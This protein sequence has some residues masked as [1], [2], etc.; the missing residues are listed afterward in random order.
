MSEYQP[1]YA[2]RHKASFNFTLFMA[3]AVATLGLF[4]NPA[5]VVLGLGFAAYS[6][7]TTPSNYMLFRD[8]LMIAYGRPRYK[9]I[10][11]G[12]IDGDIELVQLAIASPRLKVAY[13]RGH[14]TWLVPR[15]A[16]AFG[17]QFRE[18]LVRF[19][20]SGAQ[21]QLPFQE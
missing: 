3:L 8:R 7:L 17:Q 4:G 14:R 1:L 5:L 6:W 19:R 9:T 18:A 20:E 11:F 15:D 2:D 10:L 13:G 21:E 16:E 12:E